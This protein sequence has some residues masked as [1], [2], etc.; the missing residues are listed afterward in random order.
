[1]MS[2][3]VYKEAEVPM[4]NWFRWSHF[5]KQLDHSDTSSRMLHE[6]LHCCFWRLKLRSCFF[7]CGNMKKS[8]G[9]PHPN[10]TRSQ[11]HKVPE[12][13]HSL[14]LLK[15]SSTDCFL[16]TNFPRHRALA[17]N[18]ASTPRYHRTCMSF[19]MCCTQRAEI[20]LR[21]SFSWNQFPVRCPTAA[22]SSWPSLSHLAPPR[23]AQR[24]PF[25]QWLLR[26][27]ATGL[28]VLKWQLSTWKLRKLVEGACTW[29]GLI[30]KCRLEL[31]FKRVIVLLC[32]SESWLSSDLCWGPLWSC[33]LFWVQYCFYMAL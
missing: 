5:Q 10:P 20:L 31:Y 32:S 1:M 12:W 33:W 24:Q 18:L 7:T 23:H 25:L 17:W 26:E 21:W 8:H 29:R 28:L 13:P 30:P 27:T 3:S 22:L 11:R 16:I 15:R 19:S 9:V 6:S 14:K 4:C 2:S